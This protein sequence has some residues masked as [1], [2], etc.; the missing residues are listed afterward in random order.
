MIKVDKTLL[1]FVL[2]TLS[3]QVSTQGLVGDHCENDSDC[4]TG[5]QCY[6]H[7]HLCIPENLLGATQISCTTDYDCEEN[8]HCYNTGND[9]NICIAKNLLG[10][11]QDL[12][13]TT[14]DDCEDNMHCYNTGTDVNICIAKNLL[15]GTQDAPCT[16]DE[17][18][19]DGMQCYISNEVVA[20]LSEGVLGGIL[21]SAC[22]SHADCAA[23]EKCYTGN[24]VNQCIDVVGEGTPTQQECTSDADCAEDMH[25]Y[26]SHGNTVK[27]CVADKTLG[28]LAPVPNDSN[29]SDSGKFTG[30]IWLCFG[31][32]LLLVVFAIAYA[33]YTRGKQNKE[34]QAQTS[35]MPDADIKYR[36]LD[37]YLIS[38]AI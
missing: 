12:S 19:G 33:I 23:G 16:K 10:G 36:D 21:D 27:E 25:C 38:D 14:D 8:M 3:K 11:T 31:I 32:V 1:L 13:C 34:I 35:V 4:E 18:C 28:D 9:V 15:G 26:T 17:D 29:T 22:T 30:A 6:A 5:N 7:T 2:V 20:C 37:S 24:S